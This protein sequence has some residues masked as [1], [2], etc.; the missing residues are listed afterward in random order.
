MN[1]IKDGIARLKRV[2]SDKNQAP[3]SE[4]YN[5]PVTERACNEEGVWFGQS[6]L[7]GTKQDMND[8]AE[9]VLKVKLH[10]DEARGCAVQ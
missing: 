9:A 4:A 5:C 3:G 8:I 1:A 7:L 2:I 6:M 10:I